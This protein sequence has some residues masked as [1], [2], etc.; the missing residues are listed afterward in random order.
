MRNDLDDPVSA[1]GK[2]EAIMEKK[3]T[4]SMMLPA[5]DAASWHR[6]LQPLGMPGGMKHY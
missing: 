3:R 1:G 4:I 5:G 2:K 6:H